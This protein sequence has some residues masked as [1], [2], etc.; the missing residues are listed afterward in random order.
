MEEEIEE[1]LKRKDDYDF[2][3]GTQIYRPYTMSE[4]DW[5][6]I[7]NLLTRYK[8]Y[9]NLLG[10]IDNKEVSDALHMLLHCALKNTEFETQKQQFQIVNAYIKKL[11]KENEEL[12]A[13]NYELNNRITDLL[14]NI[15]VQKVKEKIEELKGTEELLSD[16]QGY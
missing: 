11:E 1:L 16:E 12:R 10:E 7:E 15:P 2:A 14:E 8:E 6:L 3:Y 9:G 4:K 13:D 5:E